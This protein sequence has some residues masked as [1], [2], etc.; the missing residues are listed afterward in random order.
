[1]LKTIVYIPT[2]VTHWLSRKVV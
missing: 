1:M 2:G